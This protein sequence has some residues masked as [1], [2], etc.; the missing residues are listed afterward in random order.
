MCLRIVRLESHPSR[1]SM[2][3]KPNGYECFDV[4]HRQSEKYWKFFA[5]GQHLDPSLFLRHV[6]FDESVVPYSTHDIRCLTLV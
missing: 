6:Q 5:L 2:T 1:E 4:F 3:A